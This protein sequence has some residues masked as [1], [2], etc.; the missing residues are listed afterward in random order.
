MNKEQINAK[1]NYLEEQLVS[2]NHFLPETYEYLMA[3]LDAQRRLLAE[4]EVC[5]TFQQIDALQGH[6]ALP[7]MVQE[8][9][10]AVTKRDRDPQ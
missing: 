4:I 7:Q 9:S 5:E 3:E 6:A 1:I 8:A 2:L 10:V